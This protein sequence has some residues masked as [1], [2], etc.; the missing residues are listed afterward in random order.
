MDTF[1]L[2]DSCAAIGA[3]IQYE[4]LYNI[5]HWFPYIVIEESASLGD[6]SCKDLVMQPRGNDHCTGCRIEYELQ[7]R[8]NY[9]RGQRYP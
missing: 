9:L 6:S 1:D 3:H 2:G 8:P 5:S 4:I 7:S